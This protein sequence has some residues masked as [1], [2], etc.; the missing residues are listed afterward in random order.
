MN[1]QR[2]HACYTPLIIALKSHKK[3]KL[4]SHDL[5]P[6]SLGQMHVDSL[7][8]SSGS[9]GPYEPRVVD[10]VGFLVHSQIGYNE[11]DTHDSL[12]LMS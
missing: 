1:A 11:S 12:S 2:P 9:V 6:D 8:V 5:S 7:I 3:T 4:H 10:S